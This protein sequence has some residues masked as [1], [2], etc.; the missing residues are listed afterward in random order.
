MRLRFTKSF[1]G[2]F[3][4]ND[5]GEITDHTRTRRILLEYAGGGS[6]RGDDTEEEGRAAR[7]SVG[8]KAK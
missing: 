2:E 1:F 3:N 4:M 7:W 5:L 8:I 6:G